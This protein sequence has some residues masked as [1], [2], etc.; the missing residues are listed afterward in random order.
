M[1][2]NVNNLRNADGSQILAVKRALHLSAVPSSV[3][4]RELEQDKVVRFCKSCVLEQNPGSMYV[5]GCPGT[6]KSLT[7]EQ[8]KS[9]SVE[10][11]EEVRES[12]LA[13]VQR[14]LTISLD[15]HTIFL[16]PQLLQNNIAS[17][18]RE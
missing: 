17:P 10:W 15:S 16:K 9:L 3:V 5:C 6:G 4:C 1:L 18:E 7:M 14:L 8:V 11:A 13:P 2:T 12:A